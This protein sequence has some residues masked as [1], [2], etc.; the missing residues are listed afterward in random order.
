MGC[1]ELIGNQDGTL[2]AAQGLPEGGS[3]VEKAI[4]AAESCD[5]AKGNKV[6]FGSCV[7]KTQT[8]TGCGGTSCEACNPKNATPSDCKGTAEGLACGYSQCAAGFDD[9]D[10]NPEN[11]CEESVATPSSCGVCGKRCAISAPFCGKTADGYSCLASCPDGQETCGTQKACIDRKTSVSNCGQCANLCAERPNAAAACIG[12]MCQSTCIKGTHE[13]NGACISNLEPSSCGPDGM[14]CVPQGDHMDA[15]C[16]GIKC[17]SRC[18]P[19]Y[20]DCN[21]TAKDGCEVTIKECNAT[22]CGGTVCS[23]GQTCCN[24]SC[25]NGVIVCKLPSFTPL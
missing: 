18:E 21:K 25:Q 24:G 14:V 4:L 17:D 3:G 8:A 15:T 10:K 6:C 12:G 16:D 5:T 1:N 7:P 19:N 23:L 20:V 9:C 22:V 13:A 11:G 2:R